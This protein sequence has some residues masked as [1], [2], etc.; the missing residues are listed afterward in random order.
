MAEKLPREFT[1]SGLREGRSNVTVISGSGIDVESG[2]PS[3]RGEKGYFE[4]KETVYLASVDALNSEPI[5]Q[6]RWYLK[7]FVSYHATPPVASHFSLAELEAEI[8]EKFNGIVTQN[9]SGLHRK[10]GSQK[11]FEIHGC[12][13][14]M[15]NLKTG[16]RRPLPQ[17]WVESPPEDEELCGW[18]P[19]VCFIGESYD[20]YPLPESVS[21]IHTPVWLAEQA[22]LSGAVVVNINPIPGELD[23][24]SEFSFRG[25]SS[26][27]FCY[28]I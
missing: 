9:I 26:E 5:R 16:E 18:R 15:R 19:H 12:I 21:V 23:N 4:D 10:A 17:S 1:L 3:F 22:R 6:W 8:G 20:D 7:R 28:N 13:R 2:L 14:E 24:V 27:Y 25:T 11:V